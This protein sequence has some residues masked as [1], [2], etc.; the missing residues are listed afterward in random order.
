MTD[1]ETDPIPRIILSYLRHDGD[2][3]IR[4]KPIIGDLR[5]PKSLAFTR[6]AIDWWT[7][8][9]TI[10][11]E[12]NRELIEYINKGDQWITELIELREIREATESQ[13]QRITELMNELH[14]LLD[15]LE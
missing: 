11:E 1:A 6:T 3:N 8:A 10:T 13:Y 14:Q 12:E 2:A 9:P 5:G 7:S 15:Q 4:M